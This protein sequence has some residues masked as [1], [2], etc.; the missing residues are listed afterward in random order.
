M[1]LVWCLA[2]RSP[3]WLAGDFDHGA[4]VLFVTFI[5]W[6][7]SDLDAII[8][9]VSVG[10]RCSKAGLHVAHAFL[11]KVKLC[12]LY[13]HPIISLC[14]C[15]YLTVVTHQNEAEVTAG[16]STIEVIFRVM[17]KTLLN[18]VTCR[19]CMFDTLSTFLNAWATF[20]DQQLSCW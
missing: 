5:T 7:Q 6:F 8:G 16:S 14:T 11:K 1:Y 2:G 15:A 4:S 20:L 18:R 3:L 19:N 9:L 10:W 13:C 17:S 12:V